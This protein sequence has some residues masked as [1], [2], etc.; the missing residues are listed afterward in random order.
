MYLRK[1]VLGLPALKEKDITIAYPQLDLHLDLH[2][3]SDV[4]E[5]MGKR[6]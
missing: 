6:K 1:P 2:L 4:M 5:A 3:D